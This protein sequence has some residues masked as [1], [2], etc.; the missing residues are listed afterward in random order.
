M[1]PSLISTT[2]LNYMVHMFWYDSTL[3]NF[4]SIVQAENRKLISN[5]KP[6][7]TFQE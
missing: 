2:W 4:H 6:I 7:S 3:Y 1:A 5:G